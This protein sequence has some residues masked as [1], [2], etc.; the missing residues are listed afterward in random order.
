MD[1][2]SKLKQAALKLFVEKGFQG[3]STASI[4]KEASVATGTLFNYFATKDELLDQLYIESRTEM[5]DWVLPGITDEIV[6]D[7]EEQIYLLWEGCIEWCLANPLNFKFIEI[8]Y[9]SSFVS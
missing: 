3:T 9:R 8:Y 1:N 5:A 4:S 2:R 7:E 6:V